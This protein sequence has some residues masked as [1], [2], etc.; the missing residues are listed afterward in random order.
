MSLR[1]ILRIA[2]SLLLIILFWVRTAQQWRERPAFWLIGGVALTVILLLVVIMELTGA[3]RR[4][5]QEEVPKHPLGLD[6]E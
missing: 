1:R 3:Q 5:K 6:S 4:R 2:L